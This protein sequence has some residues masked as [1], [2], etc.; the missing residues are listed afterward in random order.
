MQM[1]GR[2][3]GFGSG[4]GVDRW[5]QH[6][7]LWSANVKCLSFL[8][9]FF[10]IIREATRSLA[11]LTGN[12]KEV[13]AAETRI[14]LFFFIM[15]I[16][17]TIRRVSLDVNQHNFQTQSFKT[18]DDIFGW[19]SYIST[20]LSCYHEPKK[21]KKKKNRAG[22]NVGALLYSPICLVKA[23]V[24]PTICIDLSL[25]GYSNTGGG[26]S[27]LVKIS[28]LPP[29]VIDNVGVKNLSE[30]FFYIDQTEWSWKQKGKMRKNK[31]LHSVISGE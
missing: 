30:H 14:Y 17:Y 7:S 1:S 13:S 27:Q 19:D 16:F 25:G 5:M 10:Y 31:N 28:F 8:L 9:F 20:S 26:F 22:R 3:F 2:R 6:A 11:G 29:V 12:F 21:R 24:S 18:R 4:E 23:I 15:I